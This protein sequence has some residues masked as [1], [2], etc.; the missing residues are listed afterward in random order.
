[1]SEFAGKI[2]PYCKT[3][4]KEG[5]DIVVCSSCDM[6]HHK[7][8][9]IENGGCTT[10]GCMGTI[11]YPSGANVVSATEIT[12]DADAKPVFCTQCG[13]QN[14]HN[15]AFC[16]GCGNPIK[17]AP[18]YTQRA[19]TNQNPYAYT[20][21]AQPVYQQPQ[22]PVYQ[23]PVYQQPV[24]QQPVY[25]QPVQPVYQQPNYQ[26]NTYQNSSYFAPNEVDPV[27][28]ALIGKNQE[29]YVPRFRQMKADGKK[30]TWNWAA[31]FFAPY[32]L[33]YRK[34]Y[35]YG[36]V[37]LGAV[38]LFT[39]LADVAIFSVISLAAYIVFGFFA[40]FVYMDHLEKLAEQAKQQTEPF[41]SAFIQEKGGV[42]STALILSIVG[43]IVAAM[44]IL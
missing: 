29:Y 30:N 7:D 12:F 28:T 15:A 24:Y 3:E 36:G 10:F 16:K 44:I 21:P 20:Q 13:T 22:Q 34:M 8:C 9:W 14:A 41:R 31:F 37:A 40:N 26:Q 2:C 27:V 42:N 39:I 5:D 43:W 33:M 17:K 35:A 1:M 11:K 4:L 23:Q 18:V 6:P 32:W 19:E 25:Q 38:L